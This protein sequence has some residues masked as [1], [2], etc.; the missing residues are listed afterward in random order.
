MSVEPSGVGSESDTSL[1]AGEAAV[2]ADS[3]ATRLMSCPSSTCRQPQAIPLF[4]TTNRATKS[5][6]SLKRRMRDSNVRSFLTTSPQRSTARRNAI[7]ACAGISISCASQAP[8]PSATVPTTSHAR[9]VGTGGRREVVIACRAVARMAAGFLDSRRD[10][11]APQAHSTTNTQTRTGPQGRFF[12]VRNPASLRDFA[13]FCGCHAVHE[14]GPKQPE[15][16]PPLLSLLHFP[17]PTR[18]SWH[19]QNS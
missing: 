16:D 12:V 6:S 2:A 3:E 13:S 1:A 9:Q 14:C 7:T 11:F 5:I 17:S 19:P 8:M 15:F 18:R 10:G 4:A